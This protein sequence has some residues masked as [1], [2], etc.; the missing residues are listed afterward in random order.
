MIVIKNLRKYYGKHVG[1]QDVTFSVNRGELFGFVGPN[2]AGKSTT[3]KVLLGF[4]F[5]KGGSAHIR[6]LDV[7]SHSKEIKKFTGY[8]PSDVRLYSSMKTSELL[9]RNSRFYDVDGQGDEAARLCDLLELDTTKRFR[10]LS[11]G[12]RKKVAIVCA[13]ASKPAVVIMDEPTNGL[14]PM[15]QVRLFA[16][17]KKRTGAGVTVL[18]SSH[19]LTE[20]QEY[21]DR[22]AFIKDGKILTVT[23]LAEVDPCKIVTA[24]GG[25][26]EHIRASDVIVR[27]GDKCVFRHSGSSGALLKLLGDIDP[28]DFTVQTESIEERFMSMYG[29]GE[30][31]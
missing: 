8:V 12:N 10:E 11:S 15:I 21:C 31:A 4:V 17:L 28:E 30:E 1:T 29:G 5:A 6:G 20:V 27:D 9:R 14:D 22:V 13:L 19:N 24:T 16:E 3:I 7:A 2:G 23:D 26:F 18:L 25:S